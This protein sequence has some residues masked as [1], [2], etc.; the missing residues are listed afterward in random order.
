MQI[1]VFLLLAITCSIFAE[2]CIYSA[3]IWRSVQ[4]QGFHRELETKV[5]FQAKTTLS[6]GC[7]FIIEENFTRSLYLDKYQ[8]EELSRFHYNVK[9]DPLFVDIKLLKEMDLEKPEYMINETHSV[10]FQVKEFENT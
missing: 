4:L 5:V 10:F 8:L 6:K 2:E 9:K 3:K 1:G 7:R